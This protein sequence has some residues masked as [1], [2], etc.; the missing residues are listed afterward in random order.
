MYLNDR[1]VHELTERGWL[2]GMDGFAAP[3]G[4]IHLPPDPQQRPSI[5]NI[6]RA[7]EYR[8]I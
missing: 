3:L 6:R 5:D 8:N 7:M 2:T 4:P 1:Q